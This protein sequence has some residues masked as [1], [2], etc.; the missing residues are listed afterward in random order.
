MSRKLHTGLTFITGNDCNVKETV[1][2]QSVKHHACLRLTSH[3]LLDSYIYMK[4]RSGAVGMRVVS[5]LLGAV[6][7][8]GVG[9]KSTFAKL[10]HLYFSNIYIYTYIE[11]ELKVRFH[12]NIY[13]F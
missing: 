3:L 13:L 1:T 8:S 6:A 9:S 11:N 4:E 10:V 5:V 2:L 7:V 12:H